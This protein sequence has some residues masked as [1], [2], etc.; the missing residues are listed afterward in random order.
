M[1]A[2]ATVSLRGNTHTNNERITRAP[3]GYAQ[4]HADI[5]PVAYIG[6]IK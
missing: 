2:R 3:E 1:I 5:G 4:L 6:D